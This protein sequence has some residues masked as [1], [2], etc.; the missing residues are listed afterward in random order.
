MIPSVD[1]SAEELMSFRC[2]ILSNSFIVTGL[3]VPL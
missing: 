2:N 3:P 1:F